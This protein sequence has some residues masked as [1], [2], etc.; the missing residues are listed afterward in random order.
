MPNHSGRSRSTVSQS[1]D[2]ADGSSTST[3]VIG[4][5]GPSDSGGD[6]VDLRVG[7]RAA[8]EER[9]AVADERDDGRIA[10]P[11]RLRQRLLD[12]ARRARELRERKRAAPDARDR[13][14]HLAADELGE[15]LGTRAHGLDRLVEHPQHG[16]LVARGRVERERQRPLERGERE[17]VRAQCALEWMTPQPL[18]EIGAP[19]DDARLRPAEELVPGE[20]DEIGSGAQALGRRRLVADTPERARAEVVDERQAGSLRDRGQLAQLAGAP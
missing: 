10:E 2:R 1:C 12:R 9:A 3:T 18:D 19:D 20:A 14:L 7:Q 17:L 15:A 16:H 4:L 5:R 13:L 8:V 11:Q 6:L